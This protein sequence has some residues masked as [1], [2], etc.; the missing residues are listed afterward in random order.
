MNEVRL[1]EVTRWRGYLLC[2]EFITFCL[3]KLQVASKQK[4][5]KEETIHWMLN[6]FYY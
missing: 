2:S 6:K 3:L 1:H 4:Q 5:K